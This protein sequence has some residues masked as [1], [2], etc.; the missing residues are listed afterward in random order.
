MAKLQFL[1]VLNAGSGYHEHLQAAD[2]GNGSSQNICLG[3]SIFVNNANCTV[4]GRG[5]K[6]AK[7]T[8]FKMVSMM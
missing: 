4:H 5:C 1:C 3:F 7:E 6:L 8:H 2:I